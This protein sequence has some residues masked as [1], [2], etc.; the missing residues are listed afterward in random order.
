[1]RAIGEHGSA[2][3]GHLL[4]REEQPGF[5]KYTYTINPIRVH[6]PDHGS[7]LIDVSCDACDVQLCLRVHSIGRT[8]RA[9]RLWLMMA[10]LGLL[11]AGGLSYQVVTVDDPN[12]PLNQP[13]ALLVAVFAVGIGLAVFFFGIFSWWYENGIHL[14]SGS[15]RGSR[16]RMLLPRDR[17]PAA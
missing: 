9:R 8:K 14:M 1:M 12:S 16:H 6:R 2:R 15:E 17:W 11:L 7:S 3:I 13:F 10:A 4:E 5:T